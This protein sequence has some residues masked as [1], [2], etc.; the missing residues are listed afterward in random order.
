MHARDTGTLQLQSRSGN[1]PQAHQGLSSGGASSLLAAGCLM[2]T[3][4]Q[5]QK[6]CN[7]CCCKSTNY[8]KNM[9]IFTGMQENV[10]V[11]VATRAA[12]KQANIKMGFP[13]HSVFTLVFDEP[14]DSVITSVANITTWC[15]SN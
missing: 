9:K 2:H 7:V 8:A 11:Q 1:V 6:Q 3:H 13:N 10:N 14:A 4:T 12:R 15:R 5:G